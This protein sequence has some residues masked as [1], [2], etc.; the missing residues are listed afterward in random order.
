MKIKRFIALGLGLITAVST[1]AACSSGTSG[2]KD[3]KD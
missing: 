1:L 2:S 3:T